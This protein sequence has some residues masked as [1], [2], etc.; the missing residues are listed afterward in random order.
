MENRIKRE[1]IH[2]GRMLMEGNLVR[3]SSGNMS[4]KKGSYIYITRTGAM[5][6]Y[7]MERDILKLKEDEENPSASKE[8]LL[9]R[10]LYRL[11]DCRAVVHSHPPY[12]LAISMRK[13]RIIPSDLEGKVLVP[14]IPVISLLFPY[15]EKEL[16]KKLKEV[17]RAYSLFVVRGHGLFV[18][19]RTLEEAVK[20]SFTVESSARLIF[21]REV[22]R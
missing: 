19:G 13:N 12:T 9:H 2:F 20:L 4:L 22:L 18:T 17:M 1:F 3:G 11:K 8:L 16:E 5:L 15:K 7:L 10:L 6:G 21:L 14:V